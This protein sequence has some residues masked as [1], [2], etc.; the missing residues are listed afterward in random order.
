LDRE[1]ALKDIDEVVA[2]SPPAGGTG[3]VTAFVARGVACIFRYAP[4]GSLYAQEAKKAAAKIPDTGKSSQVVWGLL[5]ALRT[6]VDQGKLDQF[7]E[8]VRG[9]VFSDFLGQAV[10][11]LD[12]NPTYRRAA[13]VLGGGTLEEHLRKLAPHHAVPIVAN[14]KPRKAAQINTDL[15]GAGAYGKVD[16]SQIETWLKLRNEAA[17]GDPSFEPNYSLERV[18]VMLDGIREL[19]VRLPA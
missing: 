4:M 13:T 9:N 16:H 6:D 7:E 3:G 17:H 11:L 14:G 2:W 18:R 8:R 10:H 12:E 19:I 5:T 1:A 15:Y